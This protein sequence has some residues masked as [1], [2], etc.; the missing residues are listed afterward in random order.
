MRLNR[1]SYAGICL[2]LGSVALGGLPPLTQQDVV[3]IADAFAK[4]EGVCLTCYKRPEIRYHKAKAGNYWS[5]YY[6]PMPDRHDLIAVGSDFSVRIDEASRSA[7]DDP[8]R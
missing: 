6:A 5:A 3:R 4:K 2:L 8:L 7:S 1:V